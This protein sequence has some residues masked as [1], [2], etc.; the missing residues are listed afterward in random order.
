MCWV[1]IADKSHIAENYWA[2]KISTHLQGASSTTSSSLPLTST[3]YSLAVAKNYDAFPAD[4]VGDFKPIT[5]NTA[6][7]LTPDAVGDDIGTAARITVGGGSLVST[8]DMIGDQDFFAVELVAGRAYDIGQ[9]ALIGGPSGVPLSDAYIELYDAAGNLVVSAD[10]GG[11]NTPSGLD[12]LLTFVPQT[13]GT[14]Y[15]NARG[16][17]QDGTNGTTGDNVGDYELFVNDVTGKPTYLPYYD[18]DSPLHSIDWGSQV[19][20]TSRNPDG[21]EGPRPTGNA[22]TGEIA[23]VQIDIGNDSH[24]HL[25]TDEDRLRIAMARQ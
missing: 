15:I 25:I 6:L 3:Q 22:F 2:G 10:G 8:I 23:W 11:P 18:T 13:S 4:G 17:D 16:Y 5:L 9:Y 1:C 19:D 21:Q 12:A 14:Y 7:L 24:D 20:R